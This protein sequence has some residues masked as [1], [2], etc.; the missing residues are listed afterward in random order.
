MTSTKNF[1]DFPSEIVSD[2]LGC[3]DTLSDLLCFSSTCRRFHSLYKARKVQYVTTAVEE[4]YGPLYDAIQL[5]T[6]NSSQS[7]HTVRS[8]P[9]SEALL[10][11]VIRHGRVAAAWEDIF[12]IKHWHENYEDRRLLTASERRSLRRAIYR[13]WLYDA[14]YHNNSVSRFVRMSPQYIRER[15]LL[16][17]NWKNHELAEMANVHAVLRD[18]LRSNVCPSNGAV[19]QKFRKRFPDTAHQLIFNIHSHYLPPGMTPFM[20]SHKDIVTNMDH[21]LSRQLNVADCQHYAKYRPALN[22]DPGY[23]GWG[24]DINHYYVVEDMLKLNPQQ[25]LWL[26]NNAPSKYQVEGYVKQLGEWFENNGET[27]EQTLDV[28]LAQRGV[29]VGNFR[30]AVTEG[31]MG[32]TVSSSHE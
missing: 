28:V 24:D 2:V 3:C 22:H 23:E 32:I 14:A 31:E 13:L 7:A 6:H 21:R 8:P 9:L 17:H 29:D 26:K 20:P 16:L 10:H 1:E 18:V 5:V 4:Q 19:E 11:Q 30:D 27:F 15:T 25:I 12:P